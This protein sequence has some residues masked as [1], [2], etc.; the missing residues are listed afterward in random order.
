MPVNVTTSAVD[1]GLIDPFY[2]SNYSKIK[3]GE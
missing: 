1:F 2:Y 3:N